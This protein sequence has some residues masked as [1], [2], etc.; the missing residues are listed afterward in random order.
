MFTR[1]MHPAT[2]QQ[3]KKR[4]GV[5]TRQRPIEMGDEGIPTVTAAV[6]LGSD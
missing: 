2:G 1:L 4:P 6:K 5:A 3:A